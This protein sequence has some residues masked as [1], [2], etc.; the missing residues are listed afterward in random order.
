MVYISTKEVIGTLCRPISHRHTKCIQT[1]Q[2]NKMRSNEISRCDVNNR[3]A[4]VR[5]INL[6]WWHFSICCERMS[7]KT[8]ICFFAM[9]ANTHLVLN[10]RVRLFTGLFHLIIGNGYFKGIL[11]RSSLRKNNWQLH[12][13]GLCW[14][15]YGLLLP[16]RSSILL[17]SAR[18]RVATATETGTA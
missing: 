16:R 13:V 7:Y 6:W 11:R 18:G 12:L 3:V 17:Q 4:N 9:L 2:Y 10:Y 5:H 1:P 15:L 8:N 14:G